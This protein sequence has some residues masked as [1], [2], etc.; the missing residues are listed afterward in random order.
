MI[1]LFVYSKIS[2]NAMKDSVIPRK[3]DF[4]YY[5]D[6][7][8]SIKSIVAVTMRFHQGSPAE[9]PQKASFGHVEN[10]RDL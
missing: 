4:Q 8:V 2:G 6:L 1:S 10:G 3:S 7:V 9:N 5:Y